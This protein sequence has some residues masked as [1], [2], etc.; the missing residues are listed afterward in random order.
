MCS[1]HSQYRSS[2]GFSPPN[3]SLCVV[4]S[5]SIGRESEMLGVFQTQGCL[6]VSYVLEGQGNQC[7]GS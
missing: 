6:K 2:N 7:G 3:S 4:T 5:G 1:E